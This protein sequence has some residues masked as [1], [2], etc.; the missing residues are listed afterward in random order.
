MVAWTES[1]ATH[2]DIVDTQHKKL[3]ELLDELA[4]SYNKTGP[5]VMSVDEVLRLL[6]AYA[7]KHFFD[8]E[9]LM[10]H[11][12]ID[13]RHVSIHRMEHKSFMFDVDNMW[14]HLSSEEDLLLLIEKLVSFITSWLTYHILGTDMVMV[15]QMNAIQQGQAPGQAYE[16]HHSIQFTPAVTR[17]MMDA[18]LSLW[19]ASAERCLKLEEKLAALESDK[20]TK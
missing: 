5:D 12:R 2:I 13:Q 4:E 10:L 1:F 17:Q 15:A 14:T 9:L 7:D 20:V 11:C 3:F 8:E 6:V 16:Q 18:V 19:R